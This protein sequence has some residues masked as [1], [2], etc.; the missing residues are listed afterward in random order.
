MK[1]KAFWFR[2]WHLI[3]YLLRFDLKHQGLDYYTTSYIG[4][5]PISVTYHYIGCTC[6]KHWY[7]DKNLIDDKFHEFIKSIKTKYKKSVEVNK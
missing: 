1:L 3:H 2:F 5:I 7:I 6:E 4:K